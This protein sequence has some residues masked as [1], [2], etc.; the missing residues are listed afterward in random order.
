MIIIFLYII[1]IMNYPAN[2]VFIQ[3]L[4]I[5]TP[6]EKKIFKEL[7]NIIISDD[8]IFTPFYIS[9]LVPSA[10]ADFI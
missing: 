4:F 9:S 8:V 2:L 3:K 10:N 6:Q 1:Y 7:V 5:H